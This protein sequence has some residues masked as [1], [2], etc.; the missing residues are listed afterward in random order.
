MSL[1]QKVKTTL[2][3]NGIRWAL[4]GSLVLLYHGIVDTAQDI[5]LF[6]DL[7]QAEC[8]HRCL[9]TLGQIAPKRV[10]GIYRT[11]FFAEYTT[12]EGEIDLMAGFKIKH[13]EGVY[14]Y[15]W[16][17]TA[18]DD[19][20]TIDGVSCP[21]TPLEDWYVLYQ[22]IPGRHEKVAGLEN[23]FKKNGVRRRELLTEALAMPLPASVKQR[24][25][26]LLKII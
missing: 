9:Q 6:V 21:L 17:R 5:D 16:P 15:P 11:D 10:S 25:Y 8:A 13:S 26:R 3:A 24:I 2:D 7:S 4:G 12:P 23:H 22:L 19:W 1:L 18:E 14:S 20:G